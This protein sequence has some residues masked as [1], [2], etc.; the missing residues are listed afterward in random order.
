[1]DHVINWCKGPLAV[2]NSLEYLIFSFF[3]FRPESDHVL[4]GYYF[5]KGHMRITVSQVCRVSYP[6]KPTIIDTIPIPIFVSPW[7]SLRP[8]WKFSVIITRSL[9]SR[10]RTGYKSVQTHCGVHLPYCPFR[11]PW[12]GCI[13]NLESKLITKWMLTE[14]LVIPKKMSDCDSCSCVSEILKI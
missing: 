1:M 9:I 10:V 4:K 14:V 7:A 11:N 13:A 12:D 5:V 6:V 8:L 2:V 3:Y